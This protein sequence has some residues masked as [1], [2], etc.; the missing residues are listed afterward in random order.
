[1]VLGSQQ[2][3]ILDTGPYRSS[4]PP[5]TETATVVLGKQQNEISNTDPHRASLLPST[6]TATV[7]LGKQQN[8]ISNIDPHRVSLLLITETATAVQTSSEQSKLSKCSSRSSL[9]P[10]T[11]VTNKQSEISNKCCCM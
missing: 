3:E 9:P 6:E 8:E 4:P 7:V 10:G 1:M 2:S 5:S 11:K